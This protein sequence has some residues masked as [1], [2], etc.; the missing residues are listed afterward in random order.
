MSFRV[1]AFHYPKP[2]HRDEMVERI[3]RAV[4]VMARTP[5]FL[6]AECWDELD[7]DA[8]VAVGS[9]ES[10]EAW[11]EAVRTVAAADIDFAYDQRETRP[12]QVQE[13]AAK[14]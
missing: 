7:G 12:R 8:V 10:K 2:E 6:S 3:R 14:P 4:D 13:F 5:G 1:L 9:F 11:R